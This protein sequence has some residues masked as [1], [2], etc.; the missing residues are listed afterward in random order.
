MKK[1]LDQHFAGFRADIKK[2][3]D[4]HFAGLRTDVDLIKQGYEQVQISQC[5]NS[6][7]PA[8]VES[9]DPEPDSVARSTSRPI[10]ASPVRKTE[11]DNEDIAMSDG[12]PSWAFAASHQVA[13]VTSPPPVVT[14]PSRARTH[15]RNQKDSRRVTKPRPPKYH[16]RDRKAKQRKK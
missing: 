7:Y 2:E 12:T 10:V 15:P 13:A 4:Q 11:D 14:T 5:Q 6:V 16:L 3:L 1:R 9:P 8:A